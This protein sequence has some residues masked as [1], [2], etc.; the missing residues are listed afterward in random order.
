LRLRNLNIDSLGESIFRLEI[1]T[2]MLYLFPEPI[3]PTVIIAIDLI[4]LGSCYEV[5]TPCLAT[6]SF[7]WY[8]RQEIKAVFEEPLNHR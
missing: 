5:L 6:Y 3:H 1:I 2:E 4:N 8:L 7:S